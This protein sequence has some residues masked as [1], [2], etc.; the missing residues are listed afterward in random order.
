MP[1][2]PGI[3]VDTHCEAGESIPPHY[4]S[5]LGQAVRVGGRPAARRRPAAPGALDE[6]SVTGI[7]T[8]LPLLQDIAF[9]APFVEGRYTTAYL[10]ER[11]GHL[12]ALHEE[13]APA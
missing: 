2:G 1:G 10:V 4:D 7:P 12:A 9:D 5:L 3:R 6:A 8:T 11:A 13:R